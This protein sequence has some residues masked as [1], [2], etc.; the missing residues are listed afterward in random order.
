MKT[1]ILFG[2]ALALVSAFAE[3]RITDNQII[4]KK[5]SGLLKIEP[6]KGFH[7][8]AEAPA[9]A[10]FDALE[11]LYKPA[12]KTEKLFTFKIVDK[13]K[14]AKLSFYVCDDKKTACEQHQQE[15][16]LS[17]LSPLWAPPPTGM[18]DSNSST[19]MDDQVLI[20]K[21]GKPTL[22]IFSAPWCPACIRMQT[23]TYPTPKVSAQL[24]KVNFVKLNSDLPENYETSEKFQVKA[25]PTLILLNTDGEEVYRWLD[26][27]E[28]GNFA[29]SLNQEVKKIGDSKNSLLRMAT[30][31]DPK[32]ISAVGQLYYNALNCA[33]AVKWLSLSKSVEDHKLKLAAEVNCAQEQAEKDEKAV[34]E[35]LQTLEK[36]MVLT[37]SKMDQIRWLVDWIE[38]KKE[39]KALS[40]DMKI[41][42]QALLAEIEKMVQS[43][44]QLAS[45]FKES[46]FGESATFEA[47]EAN[48]MR[49]RLYSSL[50]QKA[51]KEKSDQKIIQSLSGRHFTTAKPGEMLIGIAYLREAGEK[52]RVEQMYNQL[53]EKYPKTYV[54]Y[55]KYA[56]F[57]LKEKN[58]DKAL[59]NSETALKYSEGNQPQLYLLKAR[60]LKEMNQ[61]DKMN[62]TVSAALQLK[63]IQHPKFKK[64]L[65]QLTKLKED[66][67]Q[68]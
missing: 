66:T 54:Y 42:A 56:R 31:G 25:I 18:I 61:K 9:N 53:I 16:D 24:K 35:Y 37:P 39:T 30:L 19:Q 11:G 22:L 43:K 41:K 5:E 44:K 48:L 50:D 14:K 3:A 26:F 32:S 10:S 47:A 13:A 28:A 63:D 49:A 40:E 2:F 68:K 27:Q 59:A 62:D 1:S 29:K 12:E 36:A 15:I 4:F 67:V 20:S 45:E 55:E 23:E 60:I 58:F 33:E 52:K 21:N 7:L 8:N 17:T 34:P 65:A 51:D 46:T 57:K 6:K 38:K 64:T